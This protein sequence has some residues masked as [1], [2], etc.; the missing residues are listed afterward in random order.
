[1][2][3]SALP[4]APIRPKSNT[5]TRS[6]STSLRRN[7]RRWVRF[8]VGCESTRV[9]PGRRGRRP[10]TSMSLRTT[11]SAF[12]DRH[13]WTLHHPGPSFVRNRPCRNCREGVCPSSGAVILECQIGWV[14][15]PPG[16]IS[17]TGLDPGG[18]LR[19]GRNSKFHA[20]AI[21]G[22]VLANIMPQTHI[23][24]Q[25]PVLPKSYCGPRVRGSNCPCYRHAQAPQKRMSGSKGGGVCIG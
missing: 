3:P 4:A 6:Q 8:S 17:R 13:S 1:M 24:A 15:A 20:V 2:R 5:T 21:T 11:K 16:I 23:L 10:R 12:M 9:R 18:I 22:R 7:E 25:I 14:R 19:P